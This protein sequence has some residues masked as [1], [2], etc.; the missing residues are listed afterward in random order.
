MGRALL[1]CLALV[2]LCSVVPSIASATTDQGLEWSVENGDR[3]YFDVDLV[4]TLQWGNRHEGI[5]FLV[6]GEP[7]TIPDGITNYTEIPTLSLE[8]HYLNG[9]YDSFFGP[10]FDL[11][12]RKALPVGN[13]S[14][15]T[16]LYGDIDTW[17][18]FDVNLTIDV[19][20]W[21]HCGYTMNFTALV[22]PDGN[23]PF[24]ADIWV[25]VKHL[26][27]DGFI[28]TFDYDVYN[29]SSSQNDHVLHFTGVRDGIPPDVSRPQNFAFN[30]GTTGNRITWNATDQTPAGYEIRV[31]GVEIAKGLWNATAEDITFSVDGLGF[32]EHECTVYF[33][34]ASGLYATDTVYVT[35]RDATPPTIDHPADISYEA[36][37]T[38]NTITWSPSDKNPS[39]YFIH[40]NGV[41]IITGQWNS[42]TESITINI[43][44]LEPGPHNYTII[45]VDKG[46][47]TVTDTVLVDVTPHFITQNM[48]LI[49]LVSGA[50]AVIVVFIIAIRR[51]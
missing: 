8:S 29:A 9:T 17:N 38:G 49:L 23:G 12:H 34:E 33:Y 3:F 22:D 21:L 25:S 24:L 39:N 20:D 28:A 4:S 51:R 43:D 1:A 10:I 45:V 47:N 11:A 36:G 2:L 13:W 37:H 15:M 7:P 5:Y 44:G 41:E 46:E 35:V 19:D 40:H 27:S 16:S 26:N 32:G 50:A 42:T 31:D 14:L 18:T 6:I 48:P 30:E